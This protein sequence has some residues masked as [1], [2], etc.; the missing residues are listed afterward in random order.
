M[1]TGWLVLALLLACAEL[2]SGQRLLVEGNSRHP[3]TEVLREIVERGNYRLIDRDTTLPST[4]HLEGDLV[5]VD[6][7]V[8]LEGVVAGS[9]G[10]VGGTL[11]IRPWAHIDGVS[12]AAAG[13]IG[14]SRLAMTGDTVFLPAAHRTE[15]V[16]VGDEYRVR[17]TRPRRP[18]LVRPLG[19]F[20]VILPSYDRVNGASVRLGLGGTIRDGQP[21]SQFRVV[22]GY[23]SA[24]G[25]ASAV[26]EVRLGLDEQASLT[27]RG[28]RDV[29]THDRWIRDDLSNSFSA[30][31]VRSD[32]RDYY[33]SDFAS[34]LL[35][36]EPPLLTHA[37]QRYFALRSGLVVSRDRSLT[38]RHPWSLFGDDPWRE[39]PEVFQ[40][41]LTSAVAGFTAGWRGRRSDLVVDTDVE[42]AFPSP[43]RQDWGELTFLQAI[44][45]T[46]WEMLALRNHTLAIRA[47]A[48][49]TFGPD[50]APRQRWSLIGG[51]GTLPTLEQGEMAGDNL[52]FLQ[53][54][55]SIPLTRVKLPLLGEPALAARH[56]VGSA[57]VTDGDTPRWEQNLA[58]GVRFS[59]LDLFVHVNPAESDMTP[60]FT[61]TF[62]L[63]F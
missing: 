24:R 28:G 25:A 40:G 31:F 61:F 63:P 15:L 14:T 1:R 34:L 12:A 18:P 5:V 11:F 59:M 7:T 10:V 4:F 38:T 33:E 43:V 47:R 35:Q 29:R 26:G 50:P 39:N 16:R 62:L 17:I 49:Q 60:Q 45:D 32:V 20:G 46:R 48:M 56:A 3:A 44:V 30:L 6:A 22:G 41:T 9:V 42:Y 23:H 53:T 27:L 58:A 2:A 51:P 19:L 57:W 55:Y 52:A 36:Q 37:G 13:I 21:N 8:R 54:T